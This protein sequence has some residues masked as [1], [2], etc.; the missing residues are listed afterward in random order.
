MRDKKCFSSGTNG[1]QI[2]IQ[3]G[4][5]KI[6]SFECSIKV[7]KKTMHLN[8]LKQLPFSNEEVINMTTVTVIYL[9]NIIS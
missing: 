1:N 5:E 9:Y 2:F 4:R 7:Y 3:V 6:K 8:K